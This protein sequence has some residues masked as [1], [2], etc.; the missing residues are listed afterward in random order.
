MHGRVHVRGLDPVSMA[1]IFATIAT[2]AQ[3]PSNVRI[4]ISG[5]GERRAP[6][7]RGDGLAALRDAY[8]FNSAKAGMRYQMQ[9]SRIFYMSG[10]EALAYLRLLI[11]K[12]HLPHAHHAPILAMRCRSQ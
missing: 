1:T 5:A 4:C 11:W 3:W 6:V 2:A 7:L 8:T 10:G 12:V 9:L